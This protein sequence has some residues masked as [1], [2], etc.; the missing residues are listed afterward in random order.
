[1]PYD[2]EEGGTGG[3]ISGGGGT[4]INANENL[5]PAQGQS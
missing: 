1:M 5:E 2:K 3:G 4:R